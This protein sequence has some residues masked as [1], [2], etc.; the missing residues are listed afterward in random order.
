MYK[1]HIF[2][3]FFTSYL[4]LF[5]LVSC[6]KK[7][8]RGPVKSIRYSGNYNKDFNDLN[9]IHLAAALKNG[10]QPV[11]DRKEAEGMKKK[12]VELKS[13]KNYEVDELTY[14]IPFTVDAAADL[15]NKIAGNFADSLKNLNAPHYKLVVTSITRTREDVKRLKKRNGNASPN[16]AHMYG[17]TFDISWKRF[18]KGDK[19][20]DKLTEDQLKM[21]LASVLRDLKKKG[22]CYIKHE[23]KQACFHITVRKK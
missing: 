20:A 18:I 16:S 1:K 22:F 21:V 9:D 17:T 19:S 10:I 3:A 2:I 15:L 7:E 23:K 8:E 13:N 11:K 12:L 6:A 5:C 4:L 14:S